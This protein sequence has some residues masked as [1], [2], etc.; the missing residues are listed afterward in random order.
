MAADRKEDTMDAMAAPIATISRPKRQRVCLRLCHRYRFDDPE[1]EELYD[2][3]VFDLQRT[4]LKCLLVL[5]IALCLSIAILDF[6]FVA[7]PTVENISHLA[8][9]V[10]FLILLVFNATRFMTHS[11]IPIASYLLTFLCLCL[12]AVALLV[13][14]MD[15]DGF[16]FTAV[17]GVWRL[18]YIIAAVYAFV[19]LRICVG[20]LVGLALPSAHIALCVLTPVSYPWLLWRQVKLCN[21]NHLLYNLFWGDLCVTCNNA[22][23]VTLTICWFIEIYGCHLDLYKANTLRYA[24]AKF[25]NLCSVGTVKLNTLL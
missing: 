20:I 11:S 16:Q 15:K 1:I 14:Y 17:D 21:I 3:Y 23:I 5:L 25:N 13:N 24:N 4:S 18:V 8:M 19:P 7:M 9:A 2:R 12:A 22:H 6:I 10:V